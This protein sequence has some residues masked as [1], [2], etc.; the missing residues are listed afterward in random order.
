M[1][2]G[3]LDQLVEILKPTGIPDNYLQY[4]DQINPQLKVWRID[5]LFEE[6]VLVNPDSIHHPENYSCDPLPPFLYG[7]AHCTSYGTIQASDARP[8]CD[9]FAHFLP[10]RT[11]SSITALMAFGHFNTRCSRMA[12]FNILPHYQRLS[13]DHSIHCDQGSLVYVFSLIMNSRY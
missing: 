4:I 13:N 7:T 2:S 6:V 12:P 1:D 8:R 11:E 3:S 9:P 10:S 5:S